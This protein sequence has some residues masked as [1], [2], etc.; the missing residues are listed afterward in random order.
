MQS[1]NNTTQ[2]FLALV[3]AGLWESEVR[4]QPYG[5]VD[6][7]EVYRLA[8][9]QSVVGSVAVGM[10]HVTD[11]TLPQGVR[12][13]YIAQ[14][15]Q[16]EQRNLAMNAFVADLIGE[17]QE[18][19]IYALLVKGQGIA[20]CYHRPLWR[21][22]GDVDLFL[23]ES[24]YHKAQGYLSK[25]ASK[26]EEEN[27]YN[28][29]QGFIVDRWEVE[30]HGRLR[31]GLWKSLDRVIDAVQ[32]EAFKDG[33]VRVWQNGET[34]VFLPAAD[35][36]VVFVFA[37]IL[38]HFFRGGIGLRQICDWCCLLWTYKDSIDIVRLEA[39]LREMGVMTEWKAFASLAVCTLGMPSEAMPFYSASALWR[40]KADRILSFIMETGNFGHNRDS[41]Y[42]ARPFLV[43]KS[44]SLWRHTKDAVRCAFIFP[45]DA[46]RVWMGMLRGGIKAVVG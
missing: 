4:L 30:L 27:E 32:E 31:G 38:Q 13:R 25:V 45:L 16:L 1:R 7:D 9:E 11:G 12:M 20:Q 43:R 26:V 15:L 35:N 21:A 8:E 36:D 5:M 6:V 17:L 10:E 22:C 14:A 39:R 24:N 37:H 41:S 19:G 2:A 42:F 23:D 46:A 3:R 34:D 28:L 29:H 33:A 40:R 44:I 18:R